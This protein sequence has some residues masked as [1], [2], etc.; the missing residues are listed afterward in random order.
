VVVRRVVEL[1]EDAA[2]SA[3]HR[4]NHIFPLGESI[5]RQ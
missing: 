2:G 4:I 1:V 3:A 5:S